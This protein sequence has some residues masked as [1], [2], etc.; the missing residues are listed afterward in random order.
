MRTPP[1]LSVSRQ[2]LE[3][4]TEIARLTHGNERCGLFFGYQSHVALHL[5]CTS[6]V[7][8]TSADPCLHYRMK[9]TAVRAAVLRGCP[10]R[11]ELVGY[12]HSH[13]L[14]GAQ[15]SGADMRTMRRLAGAHAIVCAPG[16]ARFFVNLGGVVV[17]PLVFI[18][19]DGRRRAPTSSRI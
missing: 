16:E 7:P 18:E 10:P 12:F 6:E 3:Q 5:Q 14:G 17:A 9:S 13:P 2:V 15:P 11:M 8:N 1:A 4:L 19:R